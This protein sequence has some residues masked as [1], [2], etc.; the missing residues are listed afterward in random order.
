MVDGSGD[1]KRSGHRCDLGA[2]DAA[3]DDHDL[4]LDPSFIC[5]DRP[6]RPSVRKLDPGDPAKRL[7]AC[8]ELA[9]GR[10]QGM[11][12]SVWVEVAVPGNPDRA[13]KRIAR[14]DRHQACR[15]VR[16][17]EVDVEAD[18]SRAADGTLELHQL[19]SARGEAKAAHRLEDA[20]LLVE[21]DAVAPK[22]HH[23]RRRIELRHESRRM[24]RRSAGQLVL[25]DEHHVAPSRLGEVVDDAR[26]GDPAADHNGAGLLH[27]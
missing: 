10:G 11:S 14:D 3:R 22:T 4:R 24:A 23:R 27:G 12:G 6:N 8:A 9:C 7:H 21:L 16:R 20:Q 17:D 1:D 25:L 19:V 18:T 15:L 2:P 26:P 5:V 13:V